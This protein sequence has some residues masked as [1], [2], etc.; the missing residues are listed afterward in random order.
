MHLRCPHCGTPAEVLETI[1]AEGVVCPSCGSGW[2][3]SGEATGS[4]RPERRM[5]GKYE[6]LE[7]LGAGTCG[8]VYKA[9]DPELDRLVAVKVPRAGSLGST[10]QEDR[11]LREA[12]SV[13]QL[14]HPGIV[15]VHDVGQADG[16]P[17]LVS[18]YVEGVT[19]A[20]RLTA[21]RLTFREA[22]ELV[23]ALADALAYAHAQGVVHRDVKPANVMLDFEGRPRLMDFGLAKRD[24]GE[25]TMT[26]E[27]HVLGTPAYMSP[28][29]ARGQSHEVDGRSDV[30]SLG[31][32]L[33][34]LLAGE[35]PFRGNARMLL[36]QVLREEP[37]P[38]RSLNDKVPRDLET[39]CL[40]A[41]AKEPGRRYQTAQELA[42]DLRRWRRGEPVKAR[43]VGRLE[44][45]WRWARR[46]PVIAGLSAALVLL[47]GGAAVASTVVAVEMYALAEGEER[48]K[49]EALQRARGERARGEDLRRQLSLQY[50]AN[51]SRRQEEGELTLALLWYVKALE[52]DRG[53][54]ERE[55]VHR[56]RIGGVLRLLPRLTGLFPHD[57]PVAAAHL[58]PDGTRVITA[59]YDG[60]A[61][62]WDAATAEPVGAL[63]RHGSF[64]YQARFSP[65]GRRVATASAD[66]TARVWDA[67]TGRPVTA[68]LKHAAGVHDVAFSPDGRRVATACGDPA[69]LWVPPVGVDTGSP[70]KA[71]AHDR[72]GKPAAALWDIAT[73][74]PTPLPL[75]HV[76]SFRVAFSP[77][78]DKVAVGGP[79]GASVFDATTGAALG[80]PL[81]NPERV[82]HVVFSPDGRLLATSDFGNNVRVW[83]VSE[84]VALTA[85]LPGGAYATFDP[86]SAKIFS[87]RFLREARTGKVLHELPRS[88]HD[89]RFGRQAITVLV[90]GGSGAQAWDPLK[91]EA[92][93]AVVR[94]SAHPLRT[95]LQDDGR[96]VLSAE[97]DQV[98]RLWDLAGQSAPL[99][100]LGHRSP[101]W[102]ARYSPDGRRVVTA[103]L[104]GTAR[105]W[106][107]ATGRPAT[108]PL[109]QEGGVSAADFRR[110]GRVVFT[111]GGDRR[112]RLWD[113]A[114]GRPAGAPLVHPAAVYRLQ[115]APDGCLV[116]AAQDPADGLAV[117][118]AWGP[119]ADRHLWKPFA[120]GYRGLPLSLSPDG[121]LL[122]TASASTSAAQVRD[123]ANGEPVTPLL[124]HRY[125]VLTPSFS[126]DGRRLATPGG[127]HTVRVWDAKSGREL[128]TLH[129]PSTGKVAAFSPDGRLLAT[130]HGD[131]SARI[132]DALTGAPRTPPLTHRGS[133]EK[134]HFSP[135]GRF[136]L[137][138][139]EDGTTQ[140]WDAA[141]GE[142]VGPPLKHVSQVR[143]AWFRPDGGQ[144]LTA[145]DDDMARLW[146]F[147]P[148]DRP[149]EDLTALAHLYAGRRIDPT[150]ALTPLPPADTRALWQRLRRQ[151]PADFAC[152]PDRVQNWRLGEARRLQE[153]GH[154]Q[155][156]LAVWDACVAAAPRDPEVRVHRAA[157][158][159]AEKRQG[160]ALDDLLAASAGGHDQPWLWD[161][162]LVLLGNRRRA[163]RYLP[164]LDAAVQ[165]GP[166]DW[167][168]R[169][170]RGIA[171]AALGRPAEALADYTSA[172]ELG[173]GVEVYYPRGLVQADLGRWPAARDDLARAVEAHPL[174]LYR[175]ERLA[176]ALRALGDVQGARKAVEAVWAQFRWTAGAFAANEVA[177]ARAIHG[178]GTNRAWLEGKLGAGTADPNYLNTL[179]AVFYRN[180]DFKESVER[181][182][183]AIKSR[184]SETLDDWL[185]LAMAHHR[186][187]DRDEARRWLDKARV[188]TLREEAAPAGERAYWATRLRHRLL[189]EE[190]ETLLKDP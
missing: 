6:L 9:R 138:A 119:A 126:P 137:T 67:A 122:A 146:A 31:V 37:R 56:L 161:N 14:R 189:L 165:A 102:S 172:L 117:I 65:D 115:A 154:R 66:G 111:A 93:S 145:G 41:L 74:R 11:F 15:T 173:A 130:G 83:D 85:P 181:L 94:S 142:R 12:R 180:G 155:D 18:E 121:R 187:K 109:P 19:L 174:E 178:L 141:T 72:A 75:G 8:T 90:A 51:G 46:N 7:Q 133:V 77:D 29:Q 68:P 156:A 24:A 185:F 78:G 38:P 96:R 171:R 152:P 25:V 123:M 23:A 147:V 57:A 22:A 4:W 167:R 58:S 184:G 43:P 120:N 103:S 87:G 80:G 88:G 44:R 97:D 116:T 153:R 91:R 150:G 157:L 99:P 81:E 105:V 13:A 164:R 36:Y 32:V 26:L 64:V 186:L 144:I 162:L 177:W 5:L 118:T 54:P 62:V 134:T 48:A 2:Q 175:S 40:K 33:Y 34:E 159:L 39:I 166:K 125:W 55:P 110:D 1:A 60:T 71:I 59:G 129:L 143:E 45:A 176:L 168:A 188:G 53:D 70:A 16:V 61:R 127:D 107:A 86:G 82:V 73:G 112:V 101:V 50:V 20:D 35:L 79:R 3:V 132:W 92:F 136:L 160:E 183:A 151:Y 169:W 190:A 98:A 139:S 182:R 52:L 149:A 21:G 135:D 124:K 163:E 148:D 170:Q 76:A 49:G 106:D 104:D 140:V 158:A 28:E 131:G 17:Y 10:G 63:L 30:Y 42:D 128:L 114:T 108:P 95:T 89:V 100:P 47:L 69:T 27:G 84:R 113:P 179:G